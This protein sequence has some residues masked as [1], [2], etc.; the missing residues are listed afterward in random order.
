MHAAMTAAA[1]VSEGTGRLPPHPHAMPDDVG[2]P[3][4][5]MLFIPPVEFP[6]CHSFCF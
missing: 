3:F 4:S 1:A 5:T 2:P 6:R